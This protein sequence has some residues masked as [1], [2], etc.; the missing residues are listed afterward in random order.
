MRKYYPRL[1]YSL[2]LKE[3]GAIMQTMMLAARVTGLDSCPLGCG[4]ETLISK[5][6]GTDSALEPT[7]G[8]LM[9][10]RTQK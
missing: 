7:V 6:I 3:V 4:N 2:I 9:L 1:A 8:E 10:I 5:L